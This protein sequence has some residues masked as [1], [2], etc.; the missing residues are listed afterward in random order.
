M[1]ENEIAAQDHQIGLLPLIPVGPPQTKSLRNPEPTAGLLTA[2][3]G[4]QVAA[5]PVRRSRA[6]SERQ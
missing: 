6:L 4:H 2:E 1:S 5:Y 3:V